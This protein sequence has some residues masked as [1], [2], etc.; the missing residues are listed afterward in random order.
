[1]SWYRAVFV[2]LDFSKGLCYNTKSGNEVIQM[3][4]PSE[5]VI[6]LS[7]LNTQLRDNYSSLTEFCKVSGADETSIKEKLS[8]INYEYDPQQN[9]FI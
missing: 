5:P 8:T 9:R 6:L 7:Y 3:N 1:L 4:L 2:S